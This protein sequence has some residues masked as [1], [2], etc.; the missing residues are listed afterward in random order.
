MNISNKMAVQY[1]GACFHRALTNNI[2]HILYNYVIIKL[3][4]HTIV[5]INIKILLLKVAQHFRAVKH[6]TV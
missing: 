2:F 3:N 6:H 5:I 1:F 4:Q